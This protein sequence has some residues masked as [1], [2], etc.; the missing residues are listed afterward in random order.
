MSL[1][2]LAWTPASRTL[3]SKSGVLVSGRNIPPG[4]KD[5]RSHEVPLH[6]QLRW[7]LLDAGAEILRLNICPVHE[8]AVWGID[9]GMDDPEFAID[10]LDALDLEKRFSLTRK[11]F[12]LFGGFLCLM[13]FSGFGCR[14]A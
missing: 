8:D 12:G 6:G 4:F 1:S 7:L 5:P 3:T 10:D 13:L 9:A 14:G 2:I 11:F